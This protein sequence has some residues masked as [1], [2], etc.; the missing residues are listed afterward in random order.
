MLILQKK[1]CKFNPFHMFIYGHVQPNAYVSVFAELISGLQNGEAAPALEKLFEIDNT[2]LI[3]EFDKE[4]YERIAIQEF[5]GQ[6]PES[7]GTGEHLLF[8]DL[9]DTVS[10]IMQ[11]QEMQNTDFA[12]EVRALQ[13]MKKQQQ[14]ILREVIEEE[15]KC[16]REIVT[17]LDEAEASFQEEERRTSYDYERYERRNNSACGVL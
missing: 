14:E 2:Y 6:R 1:I 4:V 15:T 7:W 3:A 16:M 13:E 5:N 17:L 12:D 9:Y 10:S 11:K 8:P